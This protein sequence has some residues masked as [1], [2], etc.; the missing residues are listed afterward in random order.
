M[1]KIGIFD[2]GFGGLTILKDIVKQMPQ[3][4]YIYL[5]DNARAPYGS[6]SFENI[7]EYTW[8][9][10]EYLLK[11]D[12]DL[13]ILACNTASARALR[14]IQQKRLPEH[15]PHKRVLGIII[16]TAEKI[17]S[18]TESNHIGILA[19][20]GT[21]ISGTYVIEITKRFPDIKVY[22]E[23]CPLWVPIIENN[24]IDSDGTDTF[25]YKNVHHLLSQDPAIDAIIL[26]CTHY[27]LLLHKIK[28]YIPEYI[29][30]ITQGELV[31]HSLQ[32]YLNRHPEI[33]DKLSRGSTIQFLTT[34]APSYFD[35]HSTAF[36]GQKVHSTY[37][38]L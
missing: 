23:A 22:Q 10:T 19:T 24:E 20:E 17:A 34:D 36:F 11:Q 3:Y 33:S 9:C 14:N 28:K 12:C 30:I 13:V 16:P 1:S 8:Q 37:I 2:S 27:P 32:D 4:D 21:V 26:G 18:F 29:K 6:R 35:E 7:Y 25:V 31:T 38:H 5:G 15:Y